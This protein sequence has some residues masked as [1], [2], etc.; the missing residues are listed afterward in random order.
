M[1]TPRMLQR[2]SH[3]NQATDRSCWAFHLKTTVLK[4]WK[5]LKI[6]S[7]PAR[8][9]KQEVK[10]HYFWW[11]QMTYLHSVYNV[12]LDLS[13]WSQV[14]LLSHSV[15]KAFHFNVKIKSTVQGHFCLPLYNSCLSDALRLK[16]YF[17]TFNIWCLFKCLTPIPKSLKRHLVQH[18]HCLPN[19]C[20][21]VCPLFQQ[22]WFWNYFSVYF[23]HGQFKKVFVEEL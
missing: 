19:H 13:E 3:K 18:M 22:P 8:F 23:S 21:S 1:S 4:L 5:M 12:N 16:L 10:R 14:L 15:W 20:N 6:W 17:L 9:G 11:G 7:K 2:L